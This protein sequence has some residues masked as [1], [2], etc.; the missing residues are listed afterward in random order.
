MPAMELPPMKV[1]GRIERQGR[2]HQLQEAPNQGT[3][4]LRCEYLSGP[5][6]ALHRTNSNLQSNSSDA[7]PP[8]LELRQRA[9]RASHGRTEAPPHHFTTLRSLTLAIPHLSPE[10]CHALYVCSKLIYIF[11][12]FIRVL[13]QPLPAPDDEVTSW[14]ALLRGIKTIA[15]LWG[16]ALKS[17]ILGLM[18]VPTCRTSLDR[19][20]QDS[21]G[22]LA[23]HIWSSQ[24]DNEAYCTHTLL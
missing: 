1:G 7:V 4:I 21:L 24:A 18:L 11:V 14:L 10:N 5:E 2:L 13:P 12:Y 20:I 6:N 17:G 16:K 8:F 19:V 23:A 15:H 22:A 9:F 3:A